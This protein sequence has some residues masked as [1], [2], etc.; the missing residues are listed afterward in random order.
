MAPLKTSNCAKGQAAAVR[1]PSSRRPS[2][3]GNHPPHNPTSIINPTKGRRHKK[4]PKILGPLDKQCGNDSATASPLIALPFE[5]RRIIWRHALTSPNKCLRYDADFS[6]L[7]LSAIGAGL[8]ATCHQIA[9]ETMGMPLKLNTLCFDVQ[10]FLRCQRM[11]AAMEGKV[12]WKLASKHGG[13][14][15]GHEER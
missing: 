9:L 15:F 7:D 4:H 13:Q 6:K 12:E 3:D 1:K 5:I 2:A 10:G 11:L 8:F 14:R